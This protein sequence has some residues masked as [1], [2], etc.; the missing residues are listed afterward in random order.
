MKVAVIGG[1]WYGCHVAT[2]LKTHG[3]HVTL[4]EKQQRLFDEA[5]GNNQFRLHLGLHYA[6]SAIT[7]H[8]SRDGFSRFSERYPRF[9][10]P[11]AR[12]IYVVPKHTSV[13]DFETY[14][15][16]M[17]AS[18]IRIDRL[19]LDELDYLRR[20]QLGGALTC[21]ERVVLTHSARQYFTRSLTDNVRFGAS[22]E[23]IADSSD[24]LLLHGEQFDWVVDAT[25]GSLAPPLADFYFEPTLLLYYRQISP[26]DAFPALTLVDGALWSVYPTETEGLYTLSSVTHT[27]LGRFATKAEAY[28]RLRETTEADVAAKRM[29]MERE[30]AKLFPSFTDCFEYQGPQFAIKTKPVGRTDD[31]PASIRLEG[32]VFRVQSGKID[33]IF[34]AS[35]VIL[36]SLFSD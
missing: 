31:R 12:N 32:R 29:L 35:D 2:A 3:A 21:E 15:S 23:T 10:R 25:W 36:G 24:K 5:S 20:D 17:Y 22:V 4:F 18:G 27:P 6:R 19:S 16:I 8:Q 11:V 33:T 34:H 9:S 1:G 26:G 30:V 14:F 7:R 28:F 13:L